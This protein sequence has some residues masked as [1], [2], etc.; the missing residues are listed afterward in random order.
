MTFL[1]GAS[2]QEGTWDWGVLAKYT[3]RPMDPPWVMGK[4]KFN[5]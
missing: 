2:L 5:I 1:H 4:N 3:V